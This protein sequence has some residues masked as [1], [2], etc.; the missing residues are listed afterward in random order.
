MLVGTNFSHIEKPSL[1]VKG[2]KIE[3]YAPAPTACEQGGI[4]LLHLYGAS[5]FAVSFK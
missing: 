1:A 3:A 5:G 4:F 2:C